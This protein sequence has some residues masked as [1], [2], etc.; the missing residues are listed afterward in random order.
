VTTNRTIRLL[1]LGVATAAAAGLLHWTVNRVYV[2]EGY[3]L[4]LRYKGP[5]MFG[6]RLTAIP[7][8]WAS[9]DQI[10]VRQRLRGPGRHFYCPIWWER[11]I[12]PDVVVRPGEVGLVTCKLGDDLPR[13]EF[14]VDGELGDTTS[15]GILRRVLHPGSYRV[16]PYGYQ[17]QVVKQPSVAS[18]GRGR[19]DKRWGW[20]TIPTGYVGVV[21]NLADN[22]NDG[23]RAGVQDEVL[24]PG[25]YLVNGRERQID[26]VEIGYRHTTIHATTLRDKEGRLQVDDAGE[27]MIA[28]GEQGIEFPSSDGFEINMDFTAIWGLL[29]DQAA[30]AIRTIGNV[31]SV[32]EKIVAPQIESICRNSGSKYKAVELLVG[33]DREQFQEAIVEEFQQVLAEKE[34]TLLY[35]LVRHIYIPKDVRKPIQSAFIADELKLTRQAEQETARAE[36]ALRE[37]EKKVDLER[38][39]VEANTEKLYRT[40]L[41]E[42]DRVAKGIDAE[43]ERLVAAIRKETAVLEATAVE[44]LGKAENQGKQ[45]V[46]EAKAQRFQLAVEA[47]GTPAAYNNWVFA[48]G[49]PSHVQLNLLYAG[50]GTLWTDMNNVGLRANL[51]V[52]PSDQP[53]ATKIV[54]TR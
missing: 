53:I 50:E 45:M 48:D 22:P 4:Q 51:S 12:V 36:A 2:D 33:E 47:F 9:E 37:A 29:P 7:G 13:G 3:S 35:G 30:H 10:G 46:E 14:L 24:Q 8:D 19:S 1:A 40:K 38:Q 32:E 6:E 20:I 52:D 44:T 23:A 25:I 26:V 15:K 31:N 5:L 54:P 42:G 11:T 21:T 16:N 17:V 41:A 43:T 18:A 27:P 34:I 49:L 28:N 39:T